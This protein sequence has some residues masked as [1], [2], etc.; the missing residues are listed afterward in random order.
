MNHFNELFE[1]GIV[2][3]F[4]LLVSSLRPAHPNPLF[5]QVLKS[6][7]DFIFNG[8]LIFYLAFDLAGIQMLA[9]AKMGKNCALAL[10][11]AIAAI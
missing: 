6:Q 8:N 9:N 3:G 10:L 11:E 1:R 7:M 5:L 4:R 2:R